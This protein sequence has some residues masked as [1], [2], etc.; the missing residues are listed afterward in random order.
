MTQVVARLDTELVNAL[1]SLVER[2]IVA[3]RSQGIRLAIE[4]LVDGERR[5][6]IGRQILAGYERV[7]MSSDELDEA[8]AATIAMIEE[9]PW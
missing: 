3:N 6:E 9:E 1:D 7:P 8:E 2:G 5:S 4:R